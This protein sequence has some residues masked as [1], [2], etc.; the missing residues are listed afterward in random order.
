MCV[1]EGDPR[2]RGE[3]WAEE[4]KGSERVDFFSISVTAFRLLTTHFLRVIKGER[5]GGPSSLFPLM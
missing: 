5:F 4:G 1:G 3:E 2:R